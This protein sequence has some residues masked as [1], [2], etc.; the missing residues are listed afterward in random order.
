MRVLPPVE[1]Y[2]TREEM[3]RIMHVHVTTIDRWVRA[4]MPS[5]NWGPRVRRFQPGLA[6]E[7]ARRRAA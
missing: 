1:P 6:V 3:A 5:E 4:G 7:W 2:V